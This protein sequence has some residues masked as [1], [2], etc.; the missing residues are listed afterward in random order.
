M[1]QPSFA[2]V[3]EVFR[4]SSQLRDRLLQAGETEAAR[5]IDVVLTTFWTTASEA[6]GE[7]RLSL[8]AVRP[9]VEKTLGPESLDRLDE[10]V[11]SSTSLWGKPS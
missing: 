1:G 11:A 4:A 3:E 9:T 8:Q 6:L 10:I 2:N 5:E 7:I